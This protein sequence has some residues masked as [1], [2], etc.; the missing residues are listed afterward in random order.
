MCSANVMAITLC[1]T[2]WPKAVAKGKGQ[3]GQ[4]SSGERESVQQ[5]PVCSL[6]F[7]IQY[8]EMETMAGGRLLRKGQGVTTNSRVRPVGTKF[9]HALCCRAILR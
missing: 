5:C 4:R 2:I 3:N 6:D 9:S 1:N 8:V 7:E